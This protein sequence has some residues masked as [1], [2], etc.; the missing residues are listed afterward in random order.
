MLWAK[1]KWESQQG[2]TGGLCSLLLLNWLGMQRFWASTSTFSYSSIGGGNFW[3]VDFLT[4]DHRGRGEL[5]LDPESGLR[6]MWHKCHLFR[7]LY[8]DIC[9]GLKWGSVSS[10]GM[11]AG[12][13][14]SLRAHHNRWETQERRHLLYEGSFVILLETSE[15]RL[16]CTVRGQTDLSQSPDGPNVSLSFLHYVINR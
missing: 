11:A 2:S 6:Q 7:M 4:L 5:M 14:E 13:P 8:G 16:H 10:Q 3:N 9:S 15:I 1:Q 12:F